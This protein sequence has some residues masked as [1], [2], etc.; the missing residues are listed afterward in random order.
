M[1]Q[2]KGDIPDSVY[3]QLL[4]IAG[5]EELAER[6]A[7]EVLNLLYDG[8]HSQLREVGSQAIPTNAL[9]RFHRG[10]GNHE[11]LLAQRQ[12]HAD[13][14]GTEDY[15]YQGSSISQGTSEP[16]RAAECM[17]TSSGPSTPPL[18]EDARLEEL[19][20]VT[21]SRWW[22]AFARTDGT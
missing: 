22:Y 20:M 8:V 7:R 15:G 1:S 9:S 17:Y 13:W 4:V 14:Q 11:D 3:R 21:A 5:M 18:S 19:Y 16:S 10:H 6:H 12:N 2:K